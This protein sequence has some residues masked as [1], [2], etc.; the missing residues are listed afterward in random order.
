MASAGICRNAVTGKMRRGVIDPATLG[1]E[2]LL[3][4]CEAREVISWRR[5]RLASLG[6]SERH[7]LWREIR[8]E[9]CWYNAH[10]VATRFAPQV[11]YVEGFVVFV[12]GVVPHGWN[13]IDGLSFD[14]TWELHF[15]RAL[16]QPRFMLLEGTPQALALEGY[17]F[18]PR[19]MTMAEQYRQRVRRI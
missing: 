4:H 2:P 12:D 3:A 18:D 10:L 13:A 6:F 8:P 9:E 5:T 11:C 7:P 1:Q 14:L 19:V 17:V 16:A 15:A